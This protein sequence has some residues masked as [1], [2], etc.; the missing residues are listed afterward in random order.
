M[1][2]QEET[3][4]R[5]YAMV[6]KQLNGEPLS[7]SELNVWLDFVKRPINV[8]QYNQ[9]QVQQALAQVRATLKQYASGQ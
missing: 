4:H 5:V 1:L 3:K 6:S 8:E 7:L 2:N 9:D